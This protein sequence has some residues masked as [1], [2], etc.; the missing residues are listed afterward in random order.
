VSLGKWL[1][2]FRTV[3]VF[4]CSGPS[5]HRSCTNKKGKPGNQN[6]D[7]N[8]SNFGNRREKI[9]TATIRILVTLATTVVTNVHN[10]S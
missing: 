1:P 4:P 2:T 10:C 7:G 5:G 3:V 9:T 6:I 8:L